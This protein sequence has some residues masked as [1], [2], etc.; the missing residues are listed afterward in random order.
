MALVARSFEVDG[1]EG[2]T[3][4]TDVG[5]ERE[6]KG[7]KEVEDEVAIGGD[8]KLGGEQGSR[9]EGLGDPT[10]LLVGGVLGLRVGLPNEALIL[11]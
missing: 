10:S 2:T 3:E 4:G 7:S 11:R 6:D 8:L 5:D 1:A 9:F